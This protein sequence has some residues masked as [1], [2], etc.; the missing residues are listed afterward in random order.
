MDS[1][2]FAVFLLSLYNYLQKKGR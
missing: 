2:L 1:A